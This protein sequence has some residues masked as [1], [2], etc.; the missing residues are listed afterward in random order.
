MYRAAIIS[1]SRTARTAPRSPSA[2][3]ATSPWPMC[4]CRSAPASRRARSG[5]TP[6]TASKATRIDR[7]QTPRPRHRRQ[8]RN[9]AGLGILE[10]DAAAAIDAAD[11]EAGDDGEPDAADRVAQIMLVGADAAEGDQR[12]EQRI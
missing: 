7:Q 10:P 11:I 6:Y 8:R 9:D 1:G 12:H 3:R 4:W 5:S 2:S